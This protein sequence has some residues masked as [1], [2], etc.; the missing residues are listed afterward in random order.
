MEKLDTVVIGAGVVGLAIGR[1]LAQAGREVLVL[2]KN[3]R[4]GEETSARNSEVIHA[5]LYY[6]QG[7]L[8]ARTC[9]RGNRLLYAYCAE[10][11]I[12]HQACGKLLL[13]TQTEQLPQ[14][15][16]LQAKARDNGCVP[17]QW[18]DKAAVQQLEPALRAEAALFSP[19]TGI[20]SSHDL[21]LALLTDLEA[22]GGQLVTA[23]A[24]TGG[25]IQPGNTHLQLQDY[26]LQ[27]RLVV[28]AAGLHAPALAK[29]LHGA[30]SWIPQPAFAKGHYFSL[31]GTN[32]FKHLIYPLPEQAG[33]GVHLTLDL[34]GRA[35]FGPDVEWLNI[36]DA[37][38]IDYRVDANR[39][40]AFV[41]AIHNYWPDLDKNAL[42]PD[43]AG[44]RPKI[45]TPGSDAAD[46]YL[47]DASVHACEGVIHLFGIESP[48]LT[49][50]LALA[51]EVVTRLTGTGT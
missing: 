25:S 28:N 1:A 23:N 27:A 36:Q 34:Q 31:N 48:G 46:F 35:R 17:L 39:R 24:I 2:E 5:G 40:D 21:M 42:Q 19:S 41:A 43:Y 13:A 22:A 18:L 49:A 14:L 44:V 20:I 51:E 33:L 4:F 16:A 11:N 15:R 7:S 26:S 9:V 50:S 29:R 47:A 8:K 3:P 12:P 45:T 38:E 30:A 32:P 6:P 37:A 10:R